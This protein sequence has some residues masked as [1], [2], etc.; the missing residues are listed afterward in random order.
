VLQCLQTFIIPCSLYDVQVC[1]GEIGEKGLKKFVDSE[2]EERRDWRLEVVR[3]SL[4]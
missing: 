2:D 4:M 3:N 1:C